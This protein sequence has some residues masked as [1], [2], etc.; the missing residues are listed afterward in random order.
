MSQIQMSRRHFLQSAVMGIAIASIPTLRAWERGDHPD[1]E[2]EIVGGTLCF[3]NERQLEIYDGDKYWNVQIGGD[4]SFWKGDETSFR[5]LIQGDNIMVK[6]KNRVALRVWAN[7]VRVQGVIAGFCK[8]GFILKI[9]R[10]CSIDKEILIETGDFTRWEGILFSES[11]D[12]LKKA[13][14][15]IYL[16]IIG[17]EIS[18]GVRASLIHLVPYMDKSPINTLNQESRVERLPEGPYCTYVYTGYASWFDCPTG[19]GRCGSCNISQSNQCAWPALDTCGS[20]SWNCCDCSRGCKDQIYLWCG[21]DVQVI[22][23]CQNRSRI[24]YIA[25][26]GPCQNCSWLCSR[27][28]NDCR[29]FTSPVVDL[30]KPTFA[31]FYDPATR[32]CFSCQVKVTVLCP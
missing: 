26:C 10:R 20:C 4:T 22:D 30:T 16:D 32:G 21:K 31:Y 28:C 8:N 18:E 19:A 2:I 3:V 23:L 29:G 17:E 6:L 15:E 27:R 1:E 25:D 12:E 7:L 24:V 9:W 11:L 14:T 13:G 5:S